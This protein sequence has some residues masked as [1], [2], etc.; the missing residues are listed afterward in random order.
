M[1]I[2]NVVTAKPKI[3][4]GVVLLT[5]AGAHFAHYKYLQSK[6][7][8][9]TTERDAFENAYNIAATNIAKLAEDQRIAEAA[10]RQAIAD[11]EAARAALDAF[12]RGRES[13]PESAAW[14]AQLIPLNELERMCVALPEMDGCLNTPESN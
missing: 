12:R 9:L 8:K 3:V 13:D 2:L 4:L 14:G 11:R 6:V 7:D 1:G 5:I 10:T